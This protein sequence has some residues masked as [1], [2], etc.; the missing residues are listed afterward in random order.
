M[1]Y[2]YEL[3]ADI[4]STFWVSNELFFQAA[5]YTYQTPVFCI[6]SCIFS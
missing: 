2:F 5:A 6:G 4:T 1:V 3:I